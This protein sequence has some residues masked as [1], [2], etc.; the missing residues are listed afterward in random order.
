M[1]EVMRD[2]FKLSN[3]VVRDTIQGMHLEI[4]QVL[5]SKGI[6]YAELKS[7]LVPSADHHEAG[8]IFDS[9]C[10]RSSW[11]GFEVA[12]VI[13]PLLDK[14]TTLSVLCGDLL[15]DNQDQIFSMLEESLVLSRDF[16]F[17]HSTRLYCVYINNL[18][19]AALRKLH[20]ELA[21]FPA[22]VGY[23]PTTF[24]SRAKTYLSTTLVHSFLKSGARA[25]MGHE[26]DLSNAENVNMAGFPFEEFGYKVF[27]LQS[28][29]FDVFLCYKIERAVYDGFKVDTEM[30]LNAV[31]DQ[32][33]SLEDCTVLLEDA[34]HAYLVSEK[35][36]KLRKAGIADFERED[37]AALIKSR[38][39]A[40]YIYNIVYLEQHDVMKFNLMLEVPRLDGGYPTKLTA[41]LEY[42]P[43]EKLLRVITLC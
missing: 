18:S 17:V 33:L 7:G 28:G 36:G 9:H 14:R 32:I 13:L 4:Q 6:N 1:L 25:I 21:H 40:S 39:E 29:Y 31:S 15:G 16:E 26:D 19:N 11:Y 38:I 22:Y 35:G 24:A 5:A 10:I 20:S 3:P 42:K 34:K 2:Y 30:A 37:L 41:A 27:S 12:K 23:I 8:F 43:K